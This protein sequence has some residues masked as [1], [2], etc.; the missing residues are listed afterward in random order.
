MTRLSRKH[1]SYAASLLTMLLL[2]LASPQA[3]AASKSATAKDAPKPSAADEQFAAGADR[4]PTPR[5]LYATAL[6][7]RN[8]GRDAECEAALLNIIR[9]HPKFTP[10]YAQLA[11]LRVKQRR[12]NEA[13]TALEA[14]LKVQPGEAVLLNNLGMCWMFEENYAKA[15]DAFTKATAA[16]PRNA[17]YRAEHGHRPRNARPLRRGPGP[18]SPGPHPRPGRAQHRRPDARRRAAGAVN[19]R[20]APPR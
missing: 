1:Y 18:L 3:Y 20:W 16:I 15:L 9:Q 11:E 13:R 10:A 17:R 4:K 12:V 2:A 6:L 5:T 8:Q 14:G 7:L 19:G